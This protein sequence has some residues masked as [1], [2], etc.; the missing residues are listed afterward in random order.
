M[1]AFFKTIQLDQNIEI[2]HTF[3][4]QQDREQHG[5]FTSGNLRKQFAKPTLRDI[6]SLS[7]DS[8]YGGIF[9]SLWLL[10]KG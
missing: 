3:S 4:E 7:T 1:P 2:A 5:C 9:S 8:N 10:T 6:L